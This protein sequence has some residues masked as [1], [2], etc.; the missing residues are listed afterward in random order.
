MTQ[1]LVRL[2]LA[3][4]AV[5]ALAAPASAGELP[6]ECTGTTHRCV[7]YVVDYVCRNICV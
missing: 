6:E 1:R 2:A 4:V 3:A 5:G 7:P